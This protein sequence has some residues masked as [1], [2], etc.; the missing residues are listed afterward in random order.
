M[1]LGKWS[2]LPLTPKEQKLVTDKGTW[3]MS[4]FERK[5]FCAGFL[6]VLLNIIGMCWLNAQG[7]LRLRNI[8]AHRA[9]LP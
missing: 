7:F 3:N 1:I 8:G 9:W 5:T 6:P 2:L 4:T